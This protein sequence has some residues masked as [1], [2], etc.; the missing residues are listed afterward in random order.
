[1]DKLK[2]S[3]EVFNNTTTDEIVSYL[4]QQ[5]VIFEVVDESKEEVDTNMVVNELIIKGEIIRDVFYNREYVMFKMDSGK[6]FIFYHYQDCCESVRVEQVDG[7]FDNLI[8][9]PLLMAEEVIDS[10]NDGWD[11]ITWTFYKFATK[12]GYVTIRW[13]GISNGY[14]SESV[15]MA[16]VDKYDTFHPDSV[17]DGIYSKTPQGYDLYID[18]EEEEEESQLSHILVRYK[19]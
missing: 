7:D 3:K 1:M 6:V 14:Y 13:E 19:Q 11:S 18:K 2:K 4:E 16:L 15:D 8:G 9:E 17:L 12:K 5:G 10:R